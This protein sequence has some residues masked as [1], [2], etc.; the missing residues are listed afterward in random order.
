MSGLD[1]RR[2]RRVLSWYPPSW[3]R[4]H[5]D[6]LLAMMLDEAERTG[7]SRPT[8]AESRA[9]FVHGLGARFGATA[10]L[11]AA[12]V[13]LLATV[14]GQSGILLVTG[15]DSGSV[16]VHEVALFAMTG[17]APAATGIALFALLRAASLLRDGPTL[18]AT[19]CAA[20]A[21]ACG[22]LAGVGW[23]R[24][25]D[26]ADAGLSQ[27]GLA[28]ATA[29]LGA[30]GLLLTVVA[31]V[32][33]LLPGLQRT[34]VSRSGATLLAVVLAAITGPL[35]GGLVFFSPAT[36]AVVAI[37]VLIVAALPRVRGVRRDDAAVVARVAPAPIGPPVTRRAPLSRL[38]AGIALTGGA[39]GI[40]WAFAGAG[41]SPTARG[42]ATAAMREG[43]AILGVS[44]IPA[45]VALGF[46]LRRS[47]RASARD[48]WIP[49]TAVATGFAL[50]SADYLTTDGSGDLSV[51]WV[52]AAASVGVGVAWWIAARMPVGT[53]IRIGVGAG[54][55]LA[56]TV[57]LGLAL[58]PMLAFSAPVVALV[59][60]V[61]PWRRRR[62]VD[63]SV[64][65]P[66][67]ATA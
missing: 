55:A 33:V 22:G 59:V 4:E 6:V 1:E 24:G 11:V 21:G 61:L 57:V 41:W 62:A 47:R 32:V 40:A 3:R 43:I 49:V 19:A 42:D 60:L 31:L 39:L 18:V 7:R 65:I 66:D 54:I 67:G 35:V 64:A 38:L 5:G 45:V 28:A 58:T 44:M 23:S 36:T 30:V 29:P 52:G 17:V 26:A 10:A 56:Y 12:S 51:G 37:V 14:V 48:V 27:T 20:V 13:A 46:V 34:G 16:P 15:G 25:F 50:I 2:F 63:G 8:A 53:G 9:A